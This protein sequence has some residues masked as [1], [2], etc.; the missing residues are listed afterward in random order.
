MTGSRQ[1]PPRPPPLGR[2]VETLHVKVYLGVQRLLYRQVSLYCGAL[3]TAALYPAVTRRLVAIPGLYKPP[4]RTVRVTGRWW[5]WSRRRRLL[6]CPGLAVPRVPAVPCVPA[7][8]C[9]VV[10]VRVR[11]E[12]WSSPAETRCASAAAQV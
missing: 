4:R 11:P 12:G 5:W 3:D 10:R 6:P 7:R 8:R 9:P 1:P 2:R